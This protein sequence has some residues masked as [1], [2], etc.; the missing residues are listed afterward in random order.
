MIYT[1]DGSEIYNRG[2]IAEFIEKQEI[3]SVLYIAAILSTICIYLLYIHM[4]SFYM[5]EV[6]FL[7]RKKDML[8]SKIN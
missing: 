1:T 8:K 6:R 2:S 5:M 4:K 7:C 3:A